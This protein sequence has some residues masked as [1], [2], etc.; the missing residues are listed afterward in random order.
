M[1][2]Q[3]KIFKFYQKRLMTKP[4]DDSVTQ[5]SARNIREQGYHVFPFELE[6]VYI[7]ECCQ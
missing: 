6:K 1:M 3:V 5:N 7:T 2:T 4:R